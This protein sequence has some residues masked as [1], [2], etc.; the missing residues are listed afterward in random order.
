MNVHYLMH[1][2]QEGL[3]A[4]EAWFVARGHHLSCTRLYLNETPPTPETIDWLVVMGGPM[5]VYQEDEYPWLRAEKRFIEAVIARGAL[6]LGV[7]LGSQLLAEV[8]GGTVAPNAHKEIGWFP[9]SLTE[10]ARGNPLFGGLPQS[11]TPL[12]WHGDTFSL[13]EGAVHL[14]RSEACENQAFSYDDRVLGLQFHV[15]ALPSTAQL[16]W[17][18]DA[19]YIQ[20]GPY[21]Q[22]EA[23]IIGAPERY[24][25]V[26]P[27]MSD[28][29][30]QMEKMH[31]G[32]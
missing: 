30:L 7:C 9:V 20:P 25:A 23:Q 24:G 15:E 5:G 29:L 16:F 8:L 12:H 28:V 18:A 21:V 2:P 3:G 10:Q 32:A 11:F 26:Y 22:D 27:V 6:V 17:E 31:R 1:V 13:P 19:S 14:A 4:M